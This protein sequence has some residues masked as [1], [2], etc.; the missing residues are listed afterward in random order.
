MA[1]KK[2]ATVRLKLQLTIIIGSLALIICLSLG[3]GMYFAASQAL[4]D[5]VDDSLMQLAIQ[6]GATVEKELNRY[7]AV[8]ATIASME[9]ITEDNSIE[10]KME[11]LK[12]EMVRSG[13]IRMTVLGLDGKGTT[14]KGKT[15]I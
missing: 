7:K 9:E 2:K 14:T 4:H 11:V 6:G 13:Y 1:I 12:A 10:S 3:F 8:V 5:S 15:R